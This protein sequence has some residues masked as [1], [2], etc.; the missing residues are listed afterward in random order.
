MNAEPESVERE[1]SEKQGL[2][3]PSF[4]LSPREWLELAGSIL[5]ELLG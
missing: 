3:G 4:D 2:V 5:P 1:P